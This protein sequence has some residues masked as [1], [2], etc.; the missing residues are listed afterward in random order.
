MVVASPTVKVVEKVYGA[1]EG[2]VTPLGESP[3]GANLDACPHK[4]KNR[5]GHQST[6]EEVYHNRPR[7]GYQEIVHEDVNLIV[8]DT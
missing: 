8:G 2:P 1:H 6:D 4:E 7:K 5:G 3:P